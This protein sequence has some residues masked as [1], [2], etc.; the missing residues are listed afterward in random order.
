MHLLGAT[1]RPSSFSGGLFELYAKVL[2][3]SR[4]AQPLESSTP[5]N[6]AGFRRLGSRDCGFGS[7]RVGRRRSTLVSLVRLL[8]RGPLLLFG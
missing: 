4:Q 6:T 1:L 8:W 2:S 7:F 5:S 3:L